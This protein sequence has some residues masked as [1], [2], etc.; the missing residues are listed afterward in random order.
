MTLKTKAP[1]EKEP[2]HA[3]GDH[4]PGHRGTFSCT[5]PHSTRQTRLVAGCHA[6]VYGGFVG[7]WVFT[8]MSFLLLTELATEVGIEPAR[9]AGA[10]S[11]L[12]AG[13][14]AV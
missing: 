13:G 2:L 8:Y 3:L 4:F 14:R 5:C 9:G 7:F 12:K 10:A 6:A 1:R 11:G